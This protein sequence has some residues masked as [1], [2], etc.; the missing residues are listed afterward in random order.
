MSCSLYGSEKRKYGQPHLLFDTL[1]VSLSHLVLS[2]SSPVLTKIPSSR[3][4][5][6]L[7]K[8]YNYNKPFGT[9]LKVLEEEHEETLQPFTSSRF[10]NLRSPSPTPDPEEPRYRLDMHALL[11][12][13]NFWQRHFADDVRGIGENTYV[14]VM[15][16]LSASGMGPREWDQP[17]HHQAPLNTNWYGHYSCLHP[18]PKQRQDLEERQSCAEDWETAD[19]MTLD[20]ETSTSNDDP[21]FWPPAFSSIPAFADLIPDPEFSEK[22]HV[23]YLR[24]I[25][26][27]KDLKS[28]FL[29]AAGSTEDFPK[30]HPFLAARVNGFIHDIPNETLVDEDA[31]E[32]RMYAYDDDNDDDTDR[33]IPG[34]KHIVMVMWKPTASYLTTI[35]EHAEEE[36]GGA[37]G[38]EIS[39]DLN[40]A[41]VWNGTVA[42]NNTTTLSNGDIQTTTDPPT[43][44]NNNTTDVTS[45]PTA[46][47]VPTEA[48]IE[49]RYKARLNKRVTSFA[50]RYK[51]LLINQ[52]AQLINSSS[53]SSRVQTHPYEPRPTFTNKS[54]EPLP[55]LFSPAHI[56]KLEES[57]SPLQYLDWD[58]GTIDYAYAYEGIIIPGGKIMMGRWWRIHGSEGLGPG[59]EVGPDGIGVEVRAVPSDSIVD[60]NND[61]DSSSSS[62]GKGKAKAKNKKKGKKAVG[63]DLGGKRRSMRSRGKKRK[64]SA[65]DSDGSDEEFVDSEVEWVEEVQGEYEFVTVVN[66]EES[67]AVNG[68][69]GLERGPFVFWAV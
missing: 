37:S 25:S 47:V 15:K 50:R 51:E 20:L 30:W 66:G 56:R 41:S 39:A 2:P 45:T 63:K 1:Q 8:V 65:M 42:G 57:F 58:N 16:S 35:L 21:M 44:N 40:T 53:S 54:D 29:V 17:L 4:N 3:D 10:P 5:Y 23:T 32:R 36:Y 69:K 34:W 61:N 9:M 62:G 68:C 38:T 14:S 18:W 12:I 13:R 11:H 7:A 48:E 24:G 19:P 33:P 26:P 67:R 28:P 52:A 31:Q 55:P 59:C 6:N 49:A 43:N 22:Y 46:T 60:T 64:A 27:F